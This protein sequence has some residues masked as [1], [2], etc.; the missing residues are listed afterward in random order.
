MTAHSDWVINEPFRKY[1]TTP[2][3]KRKTPVKENNTDDGSEPNSK[4]PKKLDMDV[5]VVATDNV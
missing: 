3:K 4:R 1:L 2:A 5:N